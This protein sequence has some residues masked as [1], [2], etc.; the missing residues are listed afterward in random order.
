MER[1]PKNKESLKKCR[2]MKCP[3]YNFACKLKSIPGNV[4]LKIGKMDSKIHAEA[5]FCVYEPSDCI[6]DERGC[7]CPECD[8]YKEYDLKGKYFC[9]V[10]GGE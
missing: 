10:D 1:I 9:V 3:S 7:L 5:M 4:I 2:C 6:N 8:L